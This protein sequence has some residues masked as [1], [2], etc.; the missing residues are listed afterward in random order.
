MGVMEVVGFEGDGR[1]LIGLIWLWKCVE[2]ERMWG[3][4]ARGRGNT[5]HVQ[6]VEQT[7]D[8]TGKGKNLR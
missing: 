7:A 3:L 6:R 4:E 5:V 1:G 8:G 2:N